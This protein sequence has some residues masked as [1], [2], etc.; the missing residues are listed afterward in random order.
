[1]L[2]LPCASE[3]HE[4]TTDVAFWLLGW[5]SPWRQVRH[6]T[7]GHRI[8]LTYGIYMK[9]SFYNGGGETDIHRAAD[10]QVWCHAHLPTIGHID[11]R[12]PESLPDGSL[13]SAADKPVLS[14]LHCSYTAW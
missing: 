2:D 7:E 1:M 11:L 3:L 6:V 14:A 12:M 8:T 4:C 10:E 5:I 13:G 9:T